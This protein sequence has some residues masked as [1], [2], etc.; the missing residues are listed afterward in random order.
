MAV[1]P[2]IAAA[3]AAG[4][5]LGRSRKMKLAITLGALLAG[6]RLTT[7]PKALLDQANKLVGSSPELGRLT[8][9]LRGQ[10]IAAGKT[11][12][13]AAASNRIDALGASLTQRAAGLRSPGGAVA[14]NDE[15]EAI[16]AEAPKSAATSRSA[17]TKAER[18]GPRKPTDQA[19]VPK[20]SAGD[21]RAPTSRSGTKTANSK[22]ARS[23]SAAKGTAARSRRGGRDA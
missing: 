21:K 18:S 6:R 15:T 13:V 5:V 3:V 1:G 7:D 2:R 11:A 22:T 19:K 20:S 16:A 4:Y 12:V 17:G 10:L 9:E 23:K 14:G 8:G